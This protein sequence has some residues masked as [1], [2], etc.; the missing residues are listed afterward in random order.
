[1]VNE[2][3]LP[4]FTGAAFFALGCGCF[5]LKMAR[6]VSR[7]AAVARKPKYQ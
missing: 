4:L 3:L 5:L 2:I 1:V 6:Y 7:G